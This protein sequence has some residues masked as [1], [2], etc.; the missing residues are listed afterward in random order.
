MIPLYLIPGIF[1]DVAEGVAAVVV[2]AMEAAAGV[3][4]AGAARGDNGRVSFYRIF[5]DAA[6]WACNDAAHAAGV[7]W[8]DAAGYKRQRLRLQ[9]SASKEILFSYAMDLCRYV[10]NRC[11]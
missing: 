2:A 9:R 11:H 8:A 10:Q 6:S 5:Y 7:A 4:G 3:A 1:M